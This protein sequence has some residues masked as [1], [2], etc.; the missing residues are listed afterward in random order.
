V[1]FR[2]FGHGG[3]C[4]SAK[5]FVCRWRFSIGWLHD[6]YKNQLKTPTQAGEISQEHFNLAKRL[7]NAIFDALHVNDVNFAIRG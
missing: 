7:G 2:Q 5:P 3:A 6:F 1:T 4:S